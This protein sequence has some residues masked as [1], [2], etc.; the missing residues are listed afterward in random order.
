MVHDKPFVHPPLS[1]SSSSCR[2]RPRLVP[3][4]SLD[5]L[6]AI[7]ILIADSI[8]SWNKIESLSIESW[9]HGHSHRW[10]PN[11]NTNVS[12]SSLW[13][14]DDYGPSRAVIVLIE[15]WHNNNLNTCIDQWLKASPLQTRNPKHDVW[16]CEVHGKQWANL[17]EYSEHYENTYFLN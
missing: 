4:L 11:C 12:D 5:V 3:Y 6:L 17:M 1:S 9:S 10:N 8:W 15:T 16:Q 7:W 14:N 13:D 2:L